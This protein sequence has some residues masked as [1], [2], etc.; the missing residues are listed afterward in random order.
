[1][2]I[3]N[4]SNFSLFWVENSR[5]LRI[6]LSI[7]GLLVVGMTAYLLI[8]ED[9]KLLGAIYLPII[10]IIVVSS[11]KLSV[12]QFVFFIFTNYLF[13]AEPVVLLVDL[14]AVLVI[15]AALFDVLLKGENKL[16]FPKLFYNYVFILIVF[17]IVALFSYNPG[18]GVKPIL[19][20]VLQ[21]VTFLSLF[22]LVRYFS[23]EKL[24]K[25]FYFFALFHASVAILPFLGGGNIERVFGFARSTLDDLLMIALPIG[26]VFYLFADKNKK[27][28]YA[29]SIL[30]ITAVLIATQSR[31]SILFGFAFSVFA[32]LVCFRMGKTGRFS[33]LENKRILKRLKS[34]VLLLGTSVILFIM[35]L[36]EQFG[37]LIE[38]YSSL[39]TSAPSET[40]LVRLVLWQNAL[41]TFYDNPVLGIGLGHYKILSTLYP[42]I[43][44]HYMFQYIQHYS[45]H[46]LVLHYLA[47]AGLVGA[48]A[49]LAFFINQFRLTLKIFNMKNLRMNSQTIIL[50][51]VSLIIFLTTFIEAG[52]LWGQIGFVALFFLVLIV[53]NYTDITEA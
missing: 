47:E 15:M 18:L 14:S 10:F 44:Q 40:F 4:Q 39:L 25:L 21:L 31:L 33:S 43:H 32:L 1:M 42:S 5:I 37:A 24:L 50:S 36:P 29:A 51:L 35:L 30:P 6:Y 28:L 45:A 12:Y 23:I 53:K 8:N 11:P 22:R 7:L 41:M 49:V 2:N 19:R 27:Y 48:A 34:I 16:S 9:F 52:W 38:R 13:I 26:V 17:T 3:Q 20:I 46:N